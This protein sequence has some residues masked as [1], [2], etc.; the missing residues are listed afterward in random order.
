M[1]AGPEGGRIRSSAKAVPVS[2]N[3][4][5]AMVGKRD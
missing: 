1:L 4:R 2:T 5:M 3:A